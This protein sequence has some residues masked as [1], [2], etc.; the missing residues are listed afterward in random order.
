M[1]D[2]QKLEKIRVIVGN[3]DRS[4]SGVRLILD[5]FEDKTS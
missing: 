1:T 2:K 4:H 3:M 5:M